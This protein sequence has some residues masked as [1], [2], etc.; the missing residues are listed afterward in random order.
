MSNFLAEASAIINARPL[1]SVSTDPEDPQILCPQTLLTQKFSES[2]TPEFNFNVK[3]MYR[4]QWKMVQVLADRFW[5]QWRSLYLQSL[6]HNR[7]WNHEKPNIKVDDIVIMKDEE[8]HRNQWPL[9]R[10]I[11][12]FPGS[13]ELV[14]KVELKTFIEGSIRV[15]IRPITHCSVDY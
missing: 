12:V 8:K 11:R 14:R 9:G 4:S 10:V 5:S 3:D 13:D 1:V 7:V 6:Q 2:A 15:F